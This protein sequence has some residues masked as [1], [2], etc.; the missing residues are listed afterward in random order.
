MVLYGAVI[1]ENGFLF[2]LSNQGDDMHFF[3]YL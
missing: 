3:G 2:G 1:I